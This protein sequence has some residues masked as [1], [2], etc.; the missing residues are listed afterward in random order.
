MFEKPQTS[1]IVSQTR[2]DQASVRLICFPHGGGG[3]SAFRGW[4]E[5]LAEQVDVLCVSPPGR[6]ARLREHAVD[7]LPAAADAI[8]S[9]LAPYLDA[10]LV[11]FGH[12]VG[13]L[14]AF[15]TALQLERIGAQVLRVV[16]SGLPAPERLSS[17][18]ELSALDDEG[19]AKSLESLGLLPPEVMNNDD[20]RAMV[21]SAVRSDFRMSETHLVLPDAHVSA[22][23]TAIGGLD[24]EL[25]SEAQLQGWRQRTSGDFSL[26]MF[27]GGHFFTETAR[28]ELLSFIAETVQTDLNALP[29]SI[30][31]GAE[32]D[33]PVETCLHELF[34]QS[35]SR[36]PDAPA[37]VG[38]DRRLTFREL[39]EE[40]DLLAQEL[41]RLGITVDRLT[42]IFLETSVDFVVAYLAALKV[43]GGYLPIPLTTP[44]EL[45]GD[46][47]A[48]VGPLAIVTRSPLVERLPASLRGDARVV[49]LDHGWQERLSRANLPR[50]G[51]AHDKPGPDN[52]A[53]CVM[54]SGTTGVPKG[55]LCPHR[56]A[57]N[58]YWWRFVHLPYGE[59]EREACN[60]FFVWE[61]LRP[62][63]QGRPAYVIPDDVIFDPKRLIAYLDDNEITR[64]LFT[65]SLFEQ[66][67]AAMAATEGPAL[68]RLRMVI[69][70]GE[71]V[72]VALRDRAREL[73]PHVMLVNDY[74]ISEC[75]DVTT[76]DLRDAAAA[77]AGR[78]MP[79]GRVMANVRVYVLDETGQ[80]V[81]RGVTGE[82]YVA[83][84]TLARGYLDLPDETA[85]RFLPDPFQG[86]DARMCRTG[87]MGRVLP[88]GQLEIKGRTKFLVK[89]RGYT[90]VPSA[91]EAA[92]ESHP[93]VAGAAVITI[94]DPRTG[95]PDRIA[96]YVTTRTGAPDHGF[97]QA[98]REHLK[99]RLPAY[100]I[101]AELVGLDALPISPSTGKI[102]RKRLPK[103]PERRRQTLNVEAPAAA[104]AAPLV[105]MIREVWHRVLGRTP[106][107]ASD[108]FFDLGGH[109]LLAIDLAARVEAVSGVSINVIDVFHYPSFGEFL[110]F[111]AS[112]RQQA[113]AL[114]RARS[115][116]SRQATTTGD[117]AVIGMACRLPGASTPEALWSNLMARAQSIRHLSADDLR[118]VGVPAEVFTDPNYVRAAATLDDVELFDPE[119][120][121][122][123]ERE[124]ILMDPQHR[125]FIECA[126]EALAR[127]RYTPGSVH[128]R[129]GVFAGCYLPTYLVH[130]LGAKRYLD[131]ADPTRFHLAEIGND[132][133][134]LSSRAAYLLNLAGPA[135]SIQTSCST[136]LVAI[137]QA[138]QAI[139]AGQ[140]D[141]AI[142]GAA[143]LTF[144]RGGYRYVEGH[145]S[146]RTGSCRPFD[147]DG[148]GTVLGEGVGVVVLRRLEEA[149]ADGDAV[150]AVVKGVAVNN[151]GALRA[152]YS[153]P[154]V[155]G[156]V[157]VIS[158]ALDDAC[159]SPET[160]GYVEA[161]G[162]A[163]R[164]GDP[165]E[166]RALTEAWRRHTDVRATC[167]LGSLKANIGHA[168]I[169]AGVAGF[170]KTVLALQ[171]RQIPPQIN[172]ED[173]NPELRLWDSPF[174]I[175]TEAEPWDAVEGEPLRA[176]VS[177][178]GIGGTN[179]H[180][181]LEEAPEETRSTGR[182]AFSPA[183]PFRRRRCWPD[184]SA[185]ADL[186]ATVEA[187]G[188][189]P[190]EKRFFVRSF[191][192]IP[193]APAIEQ[194]TPVGLTKWIVITG[195][196]EFSCGL[197]EA[198]ARRLKTLSVAV[199]L[200]EL[201]GEDEDIANLEALVPASPDETVRVLW[202]AGTSDDA[203]NES[204]TM[205][206]PLIRLTRSLVRRKHRQ[207]LTLTAVTRSSLATP[208]QPAQPGRSTVVGPLITLGQEDPTITTHVIDLPEVVFE[209][210]DRIAG[211]IIAECFA[212]GMQRRPHVALRQNG[213]WVERFDSFAVGEAQRRI[214]R[215]RLSEGP[216]IIT[217]GL[218]RIGLRL[219]RHLVEIGAD[220]VLLSR[221][222]L[223]DRAQWQSVAEHP[224]T[225][226]RLRDTLTALLQIGEGPGRLQ[227]EA[228]DVTDAA[229]LA[230]CLTATADRYG[231]LGGIFHAAGLARLQDL[232]DATDETLR[233]EL[234]PKVAGT[235]AIAQAV[236]HCR[237]KL[238]VAPKFV[239]LFSSLAATL[240]GLGLGSYAAANRFQD[241]FVEAE[242]VRDGV[243]WTSISW[244]DWDFD[245]GDQQQAAYSHTRAE[246]SLPPEEAVAVI[247]AILGEPGLS[248]VLVSA[249]PLQ[250]RY[251]RWVERKSPCDVRNRA[252]SDESANRKSSAPVVSARAV[253]DLVRE[254][255]ETVLGKSDIGLEDDFF[256][257]GGDSLFATEIV[258]ELTPKLSLSS[259]IRIADVFDHPSIRGLYEHLRKL[260]AKVIEHR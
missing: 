205:L 167:A 238:D 247:E 158:A 234:A 102:D 260:D 32:E 55:I 129:V 66:V 140:C 231:R 214:G 85:T 242:P 237:A 76:S 202:W 31:T 36:S 98:L 52:L 168:N 127:A 43:G 178:F 256:A 95:Q 259:P 80:P 133:D 130:H 51:E 146:S 77:P 221:T 226:S 103:P 142:A 170:I 114:V 251:E 196:D 239:L 184:E 198:F 79:A 121:S 187:V 47:V 40:S 45:I 148:D 131:P 160:I 100:A 207:P 179:A 150:L 176:A 60:V 83:G 54:S 14:L 223:P 10:P 165:I 15:E 216:H 62:L 5:A 87:D 126:W 172:F 230:R 78:Y 151:D 49:R 252:R 67:L 192:R 91:V 75:H 119:F 48:K 18:P 115:R 166:V 13:A 217:G 244:D 174:R 104:P 74:S 12:S 22:P 70:N 139:R 135:I 96:A 193:A 113:P 152:G 219:S 182:A 236:Q 229:G 64:V 82:V 38:T 213:V 141:M 245:Y 53:Y 71:V 169:A 157:E 93:E 147:A 17:A 16:V 162:T 189:L 125:L 201:R 220:V 134:Y 35:A 218:G 254:A 9:D 171:H 2:R 109:S 117:I 161:H 194:G 3:P 97:L 89:L 111:L 8:A 99:L 65:P 59:D 240:G 63:L 112:K 210:P 175:A 257:L 42:A 233:E 1:W 29:P 208:G 200:I 249:T 128:Q 44:A 255:Y 122:L 26:R 132:K 137:A 84:P 156:Q 6:G 108:N 222:R 81:P 227:V 23:L 155:R 58:S 209:S 235:L 50:L 68:Q 33:Y 105:E 173:A 228:L 39:D 248:N 215:Q 159:I 88:D 211:R 106:E 225:P 145:V 37:A 144:P 143:S 28:D 123:S 116:G 185:S 94:D 25:A 118:G 197:A 154:G 21:L 164:I 183:L 86:G 56:G 24:D 250:P 72:T 120:F 195:A 27:P 258:L 253:D 241:A 177:S 232:A 30:L 20:L 190:W 61:V 191:A 153:A 110:R 246:L 101:P 34:R 199:S 107:H 124:A 138:V 212:S 188:R 90:I 73:L 206:A 224:D 11:L 41:I 204:Q 149:V 186:A 19:L 57:V 203:A 7:N 46:I 92:I 243:P 163:T 4:G 69:L 136:G 180:V 181:I